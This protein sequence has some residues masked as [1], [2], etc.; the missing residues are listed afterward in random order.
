MS[1]EPLLCVD[2]T[3]SD[4]AW[5]ERVP[6]WDLTCVQG[7]AE[8]TH[9]MESEDYTLGILA[10]DTADRA[11]LKRLE[12]ALTRDIKMEWVALVRTRS[13]NRDLAQFISRNCCDYHTIPLDLDRLLVTL[14]HARGMA[15]IGVGSVND[16]QLDDSGNF[17]MVGVSAQ[18]QSVFR[19]IRKIARVDAPILIAG[20]SGTGKEL[21]ARAIHERSDRARAPFIA[22]N[23]GALPATLIHS[24]LFGHEKGAFTDAGSRKIGRFEAAAGG[25][26]FL[27]EIGDLPSDIQITL[28]RFLQE[29]TIERLGSTQSIPIDARVIAATHVDMERAVAEG[30][31]R[32]DLY[33]RLNVLRLVMPPLRARDGDVEILARFF[34]NEFVGES[35]NKVTGFSRECTDCMLRY[36]WPGNV[37]ELINRVRRALVMCED[38]LI[39]PAD[40]GLEQRL[41]SRPSHTLEKARALADVQAI[42]DALYRN[43][44]NVTRAAEDLEISR[45]TLYRLIE[46]YNLTGLMKSPRQRSVAPDLQSGSHQKLL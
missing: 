18:M 9:Q 36:H 23:C 12:Y 19:A 17:E 38:R 15:E 14:G 13:M 16:Q 31:F 26:I 8:A 1:S 29:K 27:D 28:L 11:L 37:R 2:M 33:Y 42:Q 46:K 21:A 41:G 30:R 20:E 32:E 44:N 40:M 10:L 4:F 25:T 34:F 39:S 43:N 5:P 7:L 6:G 35:E 3:E 45:I 22:V 24:E